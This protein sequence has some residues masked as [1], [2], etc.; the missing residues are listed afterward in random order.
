MVREG[1]V[2]KYSANAKQLTRPRYSKR[3]AKP[4]S[5]YRRGT[6]QRWCSPTL[7][8]ETGFEINEGT[9]LGEVYG[10]EDGRPGSSLHG[11]RL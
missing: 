4:Q 7:E 11:A 2:V 9:E 5:A 3:H 8:D 10:E 1:G 6:Q